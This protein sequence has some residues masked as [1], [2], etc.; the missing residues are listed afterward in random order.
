[1]NYDGVFV[2]DARIIGRMK[3]GGEHKDPGTSGWALP[4][5]AVYLGIGEAALDAACHYAN[6]RVPV[7]LGKPIAGASHIQQW[8]GDMEVRLH[9][10]RTVLHDVARAAVAQTLP[11]RLSARRSRQRKI[12]GTN[13][14]CTATETALRVAGGFQHDTRP[15]AGAVFPRCP[16]RLVP[17][18]AG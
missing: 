14:A 17:A 1:M 10:A 7:A 6:N 5:A 8:I 12:P 4:L 15:A 2:A 13:A 18:P 9:A 16:R 11:P 3:I